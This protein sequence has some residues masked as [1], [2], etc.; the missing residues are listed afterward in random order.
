MQKM[1]RRVPSL[2]GEWVDEVA[3]FDVAEFT[4]GGPGFVEAAFGALAADGGGRAMVGA[5][6]TQPHP[7]ALD[8]DDGALG[9]AP[10]RVPGAAG[11]RIGR[12]AGGPGAGG[13]PA[14]VGGGTGAPATSAT[15]SG[16]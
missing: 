11:P 13:A 5:A 12:G 6:G 15:A 3:V 16:G 8:A 2:T 14:P 10:P 9:V 4:G 7:V 1:L